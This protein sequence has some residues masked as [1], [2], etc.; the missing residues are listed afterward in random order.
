VAIGSTTPLA[1]SAPL[2]TPSGVRKRSLLSEISRHRTDY[3][4]VAP[5]LLVMGLVIGYPFVYTID[6]SFYE[7]PPSSPNWYFNGVA[8][9]TQILSDP[10]FWAITLNTFYWAV[11]STVLAFLVGLGAALVVQREFIGRGLVRGLLMIPYVISYVAAAYVWRW[12]YHS[13]YGLISGVLYDHYIIDA[14]INF[15]DS[16][17]NVLPSLIVANVWKEFPFAMIMMLAGLQTVP[18]QLLNAARVDGADAWNRFVHVTLPSLRGVML[19][20]SILLFVGN[21]N[22]F[23]LVWIMT[24][25]GPANASQIWITE[26]YTLAFQAL[27]YGRASAYSVILFI[28]MLALGYFYVRSL[29][30]GGR[31]RDVRG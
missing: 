3:L 12:L 19:I 10:S 8:N 5:A 13:D 7:T 1:G 17:T 21:L 16:T 20:T 9:Y 18:Q 4:W 6:L 2:T 24:G 27:Q 15:L 29:T 23:G 11:G 31:G 25:G 28:V 30:G 22:S 26:V 14:P